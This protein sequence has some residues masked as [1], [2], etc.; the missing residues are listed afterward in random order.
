M[1]RPRRAGESRRVRDLWDRL[2]IGIIFREAQALMRDPQFPKGCS[3]VEQALHRSRPRTSPWAELNPGRM[4]AVKGFIHVV[5][6]YV[7]PNDGRRQ[8]RSERLEPF[9]P[10]AAG[11]PA[12]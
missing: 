10:R 2:E 1:A 5:A 9:L 11:R 6:G 7:S 8:V 12:E 4:V 3:P